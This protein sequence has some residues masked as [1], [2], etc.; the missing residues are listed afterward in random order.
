MMRRNPTGITGIPVYY[1]QR[2]RWKVPGRLAP[3]SEYRRVSELWLAEGEAHHDL[4][5][6]AR[7]LQMQSTNDYGECRKLW[8][9]KGTFHAIYDDGC[10]YKFS[11]VAQTAALRYAPPFSKPTAHQ[12]R[13]Q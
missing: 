11:V 10:E 3:E 1:V 9:D 7:E 2:E 12:D 8:F 5:L 6:I 13:K 4:N